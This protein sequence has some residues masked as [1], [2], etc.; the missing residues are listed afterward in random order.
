[1]EEKVLKGWKEIQMLVCMRCARVSKEQVHGF[2][3][4]R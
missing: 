4:E 2:G 3:E 1:M